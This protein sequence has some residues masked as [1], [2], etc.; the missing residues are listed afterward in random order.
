MEAAPRRRTRSPISG[1]DHHDSK[2]SRELTCNTQATACAQRD[3]AFEQRA[4]QPRRRHAGGAARPEAATYGGPGRRGVPVRRGRG[5]SAWAKQALRRRHAAQGAPPGALGSLCAHEGVATKRCWP[6][7][8]RG[9]GPVPLILSRRA[10]APSSPPSTWGA[11]PS[12]AG[13]R[14]PAMPVRAGGGRVGCRRPCVRQAAFDCARGASA[15][16]ACPTAT[17]AP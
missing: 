15:Q 13:R 1:A 4:R 11:G 12:P 6:R 2:A 14:E 9:Q 16:D 8:P 17:A 7:S 5:S 3:S 10:P